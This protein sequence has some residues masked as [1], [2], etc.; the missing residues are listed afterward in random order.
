MRSGVSGGGEGGGGKRGE[1]SLQ[2]RQRDTSL[3]RHVICLVCENETFLLSLP[4][5]QSAR[6]RVFCVVLEDI[7]KHGE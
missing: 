4:L 3:C 7:V 6:A 2:S 5:P 1:V